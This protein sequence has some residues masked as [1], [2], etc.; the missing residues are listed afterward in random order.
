[1]DALLAALQAVMEPSPGHAECAGQT[2]QAAPSQKD[3]GMAHGAHVVA[4]AAEKVPAAQGAHLEAPAEAEKKF[5]SQAES[6]P[7]PGH[8]E[9]AAQT[10]QPVS[11]F[12]QLP[13]PQCVHA[14]APASAYSP[15]ATAQERDVPSPGQ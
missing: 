15:F 3:P 8:D 4:P 12:H 10:W 9:P 11:A 5:A 2:L 1:M 13:A 6:V 7:S 14:E